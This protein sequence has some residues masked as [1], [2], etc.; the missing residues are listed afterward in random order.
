MIG[1]RTPSTT[2]RRA[3]RVRN[4]LGQG[5]NWEQLAKFCVVGATG[6]LVNLGVYTLLL[7]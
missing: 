2:R 4:A 3:Q 6:Y 7:K 5:S 1:R